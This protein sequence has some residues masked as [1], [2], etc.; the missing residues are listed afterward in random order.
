MAGIAG[1]GFEVA[2]I[3]LMFLNFFLT[4][5]VTI[6]IFSLFVYQISC[7]IENQTSVEDYICRRARKV[8]RRQGIVRFV[9]WSYNDESAQDAHATLFEQKNFKWPYD[10]G[11]SH[12]VKSI[13]GHS[14]LGW[15]VPFFS[16]DGDGMRFK[17]RNM[18]EVES[19]EG[20]VDVVVKKGSFIC[21]RCR[22][23]PALTNLCRVDDSTHKRHGAVGMG[24]SKLH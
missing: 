8:A 2:D 19:E 15:F 10:F 9:F 23:L 21:R 16:T 1:M 4:L 18:V 22:I 7:V 13:Y 5:P 12:N 6:A 3:I 14:F 24:P 11:F 20:V 17:V